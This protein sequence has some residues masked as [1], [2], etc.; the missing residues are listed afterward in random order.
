MPVKYPD[1]SE[2]YGYARAHCPMCRKHETR[3]IPNDG[4]I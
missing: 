4:A 3:Q 1:A 2:P